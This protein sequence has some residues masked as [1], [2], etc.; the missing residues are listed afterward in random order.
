MSRIVTGWISKCSFL[1]IDPDPRRRLQVLQRYVPLVFLSIKTDM[2]SQLCSLPQGTLH[3]LK[4]LS[5]LPSNAMS[6][7]EDNSD[8]IPLSFTY[9]LL[10][11]IPAIYHRL[12]TYNEV[13]LSLIVQLCSTTQFDDKSSMPLCLTILDCIN[14]WLKSPLYET[15][16]KRYAFIFSSMILSSYTFTFQQ[17]LQTPLL[18]FILT[19]FSLPYDHPIF[20]NEYILY[21][22]NIIETLYSYSLNTNSPLFL[23]TEKGK[24]ILAVYFQIAEKYMTMV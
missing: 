23:E 17:L 10:V 6:L 1:L 5:I 4:T 21:S 2:F 14:N 3:Y 16:N 13:L 18:S 20:D 9:H 7:F 24:A 11:R 22:S 15:D 12:S 8:C 19:F